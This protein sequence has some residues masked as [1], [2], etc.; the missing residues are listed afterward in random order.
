MIGTTLGDLRRHIDSL[1]DPTGAYRICCGRT[2]E[3]PVPVAGLAFT[4]RETAR[5]AIRCGEQYRAA[6]RRYDP[7]VPVYDLVAVECPDGSLPTTPFS[8]ARVPA[9]ATGTTMPEDAAGDGS[10]ASTDRSHLPD[11]AIDLCHTVAG[12]VFEAIADSPYATLQDAIM[13]EYLAAAERVDEPDE[14]CLQLLDSIAVELDTRLDDDE[15]ARL[16]RAAGRRLSAR[17]PPAQRDPVTAILD[18]LQSA[19]MLGSYAVSTPR[20]D[21]D[22]TAGRWRVEVDGYALADHEDDRLVTLPVSVALFGRASVRS[23]AI[24]NVTR[25]TSERWRLTAATNPSGGPSGLTRVHPA[26]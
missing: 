24:T 5:A 26:S 11:S 18:R 4:D 7:Q 1:A 19:G 13:D 15:T 14:L 23:A 8:Q 20:V 25:P 3:R 21:L 12:A 6:L 2:G 17:E 16:L 22:Q 10:S 9:G